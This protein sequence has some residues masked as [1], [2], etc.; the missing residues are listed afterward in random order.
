MRGRK[1]PL[2]IFR[3]SGRSFVTREGGPARVEPAEGAAE[4]R[5]VRGA[6]L[7]R[8]RAVAAEREGRR[9]PPD[10]G[11][12]APDVPRPR[13]PRRS[14]SSSGAASVPVGRVALVLA[15]LVLVVGAA[16]ALRLGPFAPAD[17]SGSGASR[18]ALWR[19]APPEPEEPAEAGATPESAAADVEWWVLAASEKLTTDERRATWKERFGHDKQRIAKAL[20]EEFP[21][22]RIERATDPQQTE[23]LLRVGPAAAADDPTLQAA[24]ARVRGLGGG[25]AS[26]HVKKFRK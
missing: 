16:Y 25:F 22:L 1:H 3:E 19:N 4:R 5:E 7:A 23:A 20:G 6:F 13:A 17:G 2:E 10:E 15:T 21:G 18:Y 9:P 14:W 26:A 12:E 24:L 8:A 11:G